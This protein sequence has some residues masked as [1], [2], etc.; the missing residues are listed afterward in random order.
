MVLLL[1]HLLN[2]T[3]KIAKIPLLEAKTCFCG[4]PISLNVLEA[5]ELCDLAKLN[6]KI[7]MVG[8]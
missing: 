2:I 6:N 8:H 3:V 7:L 1:L 5:E 4:K